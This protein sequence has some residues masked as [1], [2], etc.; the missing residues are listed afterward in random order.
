MY[1]KFGNTRYNIVSEFRYDFGVCLKQVQTVLKTHY[2]FLTKLNNKHCTSYITDSNKCTCFVVV[3][4]FSA[5]NVD[6]MGN[7]KIF[8]YTNQL[9]ILI[10]IENKIHT[11]I[12][13][14]FLGTHS[15][16]NL[17]GKLM[18]I[19]FSTTSLINNMLY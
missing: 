10:K 8:A 9:P 16:N 6:I 4:R 12:G 13:I 15:L 1:Y 14:N 11:T 17:F 19:V 2:I 18:F 5:D 7:I 3:I